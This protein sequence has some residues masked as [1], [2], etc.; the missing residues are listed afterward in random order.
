[1]ISIV[2]FNILRLVNL[3][4]TQ[5]ASTHLSLSSVK[6][7]LDYNQ[8]GNQSQQDQV[9]A[10]ENNSDVTLGNPNTQKEIFFYK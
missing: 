7:K 4:K 6:H 5:S 3:Q 9:I 8:F 2:V 10:K 1:M